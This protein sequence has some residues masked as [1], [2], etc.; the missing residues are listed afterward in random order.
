MKIIINAINLN[1]ETIKREVFSDV[2]AFSVISRLATEGCKEF[3]I[4]IVED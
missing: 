1:G 3:E 2:Q 4:K